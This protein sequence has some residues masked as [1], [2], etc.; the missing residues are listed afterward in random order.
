MNDAK[1]RLLV[2]NAVKLDRDIA[3]KE[4]LLKT[5]KD[6]LSAEAK[7]R[8]ATA[9]KTEGGGTSLTLEG[10]DGCVCRIT[11]TGRALKSSL[12][13]LSDDFDDIKEASGRC[14]ADLFDTVS[15][16]TPVDDFRTEAERLLGDKAGALISL[17]SN[18]GKTTVSFETKE[19]V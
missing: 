9:T 13:P 14:F 5:L 8:K 15:S 17:F 19:A 1:L 11:R 16:Y 2:T 12:N 6:Q 3:R 4:A 7:A 10:N 18:A